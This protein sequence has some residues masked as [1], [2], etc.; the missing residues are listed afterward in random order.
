MRNSSLAT[1]RLGATAAPLGACAG[2]NGGLFSSGDRVYNPDTVDRGARDGDRVYRDRDGRYYCKREDGTTGTLVGAGVG[3]LLG[4][5]IAPGG[6][7]TIGTI[8]GGAAGAVGGRAID[9]S[10]LACK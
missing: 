8:L 3:A 6:S 5:L 9:R 10:D 1:A 7:K 4:N 2:Y